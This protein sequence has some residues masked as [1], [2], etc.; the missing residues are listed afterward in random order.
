MGVSLRSNSADIYFIFTKYRRCSS[1]QQPLCSPQ[2]SGA[3]AAGGNKVLQTTRP[4]D[5]S[6][7]L[8]S[9]GRTV[10]LS[11]VRHHGEALQLP[12]GYLHVHHRHPDRNC[13]QQTRSYSLVSSKPWL[14]QILQEA[15]RS[16]DNLSPGIST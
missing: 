12:H 9:E 5:N 16:S 4:L 8:S 3:H 1:A 6:W 2:R 13:L 10:Y 15:T 11:Y 7:P 14:E